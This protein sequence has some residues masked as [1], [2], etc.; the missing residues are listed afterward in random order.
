MLK[1][2]Q[3][4]IGGTYTREKKVKEEDTAI[5]YG[6]G[7]LDNLLATQNLIAL[8]VEASK[9]LLDDKLPNGFITVGKKI[10]FNHL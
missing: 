8:M 5:K 10:Q 9:E 3:L 2:P 6:R 1:I 7:Q 4:E